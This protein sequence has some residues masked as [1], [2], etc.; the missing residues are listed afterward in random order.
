MAEVVHE[1]CNT[2]KCWRLPA[3]FLNDKGRRL[4]SCTACR[5]RAQ[6]ARDRHKC[7]HGRSKYTC[8]PCGGSS[9]CEH[10]SERSRCKICGGGSSICEHNKRRT[11]CKQCV[12]GSICEHGRVRYHCNTCTPMSYLRIIAR[13]RIHGALKGT[14]V[15]GSFD[16][17]G[18]TVQDFKDH[19]TAQLHDGMT[20]ENY[21]KWHIDHIVPLKY[22]EPTVED[23]VERLHYTNTQPLWAADNIA[24]RNKYI[25]HPDDQC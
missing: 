22:G 14:G 25:G 13:S 24:K 18:C 10:N 9:T 5:A 15:A 4:K 6:L 8:R 20:W 1:R 21:G 3:L 7:E 17:L 19:I 16:M 23:M 2:C 11:Q 12:G